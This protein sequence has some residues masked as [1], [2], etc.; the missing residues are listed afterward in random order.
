MKLARWLIG[1]SCAVGIVSADP[2]AFSQPVNKVAQHS[3]SQWSTIGLYCFGC[4]NEEVRAG[5]LFLDQLSAESVPEHPEIFEK[6][7]RKL[8]GRQMPP[9][10]IDQPSQQDVDALISWLETTLDKSSKA[11]LAGRVPVQRLN[12]TEYANAVQDLLAVE[13]DP[14]KYLPAD[15]AVEGFSNI[16][17]ALT[18]SPAFLEQYVNAARVVSR[19]AVGKPEPEVVKASFPPPAIGDQDGYVDGMPLGTRGGTRFEYTFPADGEYRVTIT[20]LDFGLYPRGTENETTV[21]VLIDRKEVFR[22]KVGGE[23][24][25]AFVDRGGGAPAGAKLME[26]FANIPVQVTAGVHEVVVTFIERSRVATDDLVAGG[27]QYSGFA[28]KGYLRLPRVIGSIQL[29][30]PYAATSPTRTPSREKLFICKPETP[31][32]ERACAERI[33]ADLAGRAF[34]RPI[35][36][37]DTDGLMAFYDAGREGSGG[38]NA[39]IQGM[40]TAVLVSPDFLYRGIARPQD[41]KDAKFYALSDL[42]LASRLSFFLWKRAPDE[43]LLKLAKKGELQRPGVLDAQVR[44]MLAAPHA[45]TLVTDFALRWLDLL[46]VDKFEWDKQIFPEFSAELRQDVSTEI[47]LFLRSILLEDKNVELLLTADY[48]FLNERLARHYGITTVHGAQFRR[49]HLEDENR[50]GLLGKGAVLLHTS[51]G[52]RTSPVVR[53]AWVLDKLRGTP[54]APPPPNVVTDLST[55]PGAQPKTMRL[56]LE[57]H[58]KNPTCNMCHGVIE[59]HGLPL[60]RFTVTG[61]WR[62]V[63]WQANAPIDSKV[64]MPDGR[65]LEG[66]ADLRRALMSRPGQFAQALTQKLMMYALG[67]E[68]APYDMP[69]VRAIARAA[70]KDDYRFSSLVAGIVSSDAFRMQALEE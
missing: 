54:P 26:R 3:E 35:T 7:V 25:R 44:R 32:Q 67:R 5:N 15:I 68:I 17:A 6:V 45:E 53:G 13:I 47:D 39:G 14:T 8:R 43:E 64:T 58:R 20:D 4:H 49:V 55:P 42:E 37:G 29:A 27:T 50:Y 18:V 63:D 31:E 33:T 69:Q 30:G 34:R 38:F 65:E 48:T 36:K 40:V 11:H 70:A 24:D 21:V 10:G 51:Y 62:D 2:K 57:E 46:E 1:I 9:P 12:R 22:Q 60:E 52:N 59:P 28:F 61:Q 23:A 41:K 16:A 19:M 66:P 56:M